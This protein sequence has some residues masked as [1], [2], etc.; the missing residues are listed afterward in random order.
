ML[1]PGFA[2]CGQVCSRAAQEHIP[3]PCP[4]QVAQGRERCVP[5]VTLE[6][7]TTTAS[8]CPRGAPARILTWKHPSAPQRT[9]FGKQQQ[10]Q[11]QHGRPPRS[12]APRVHGWECSCLSLLL[13][14]WLHPG[15]RGA[16]LLPPA[17]SGP[18]ASLQEPAPTLAKRD[19]SP[20]CG[21]QD[22]PPWRRWQRSYPRWQSG[23]RAGSRGRLLEN[24]SG[25]EQRRWLSDPCSR[26]RARLWSCSP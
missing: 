24:F 5:V 8:P 12:P 26:S 18:C 13:C 3:F 22:D 14:C 17:L 10:Q 1:P 6:P 15:W 20:R 2:K 21:S 23:A 9:R 25:A 4:G 16:R 19:R 7:M 11:Q